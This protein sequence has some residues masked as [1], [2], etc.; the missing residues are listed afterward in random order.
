MVAGFLVNAMAFAVVSVSGDVVSLAVLLFVAGI[1]GSTYHPMGIPL[2]SD[3]FPTKR[4]EALGYHQTG[5]SVGSFIAPLIVGVLAETLGWR[6]AFLTLSMFG[7]VLVPVLWKRLGDLPV[8][9]VGGSKPSLGEL[10]K[11]LT[12]VLAASM[13]IVASRGLQ[14]FGT[15]YFLEG[16]DLGAQAY[17]LLSL[18][19]VAGIFSGPICGRL[20]DMMGR[21]EVI[22]SLVLLEGVSAF[23]IA[24]LT[25]IP[26]YLIVV[27]FG[28]SVYG[29]LATMDAF[30]ADVTRPQ[31]FG[32]IIG[33]NMA[34]SFVV[35]S[36]LP[37]AL[38]ASIS[39]YGYDFS[40]AL[41][42]VFPFLSVPLILFIKHGREKQ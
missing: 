25:G 9:V 5:G 26:L 28:F 4:G 34:S 22:L 30:I 11:P 3:L 7:F 8:K 18:S 31:L 21:K 38:G 6:S 12:L 36:V 15:Y 19:H 1:G 37:P 24:L 16:K 35:L 2:I 13:Y 29:L 40:F 41:L 20:S 27:V 23:G 32:T 10:R 14:S 39:A 42:A 33:I 17:V